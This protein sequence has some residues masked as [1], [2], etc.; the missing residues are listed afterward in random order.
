MFFNN[1]FNNTSG[2]PFNNNF[3]NTLGSSF[4]NNF[5]II[6]GTFLIIILIIFQELL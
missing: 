1:N 3:N 6:S 5:N 4:N 2:S